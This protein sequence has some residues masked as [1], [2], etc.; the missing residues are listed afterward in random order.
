MT[1]KP[2]IL[3]AW[4]K[5][6]AAR[7]TNPARMIK[8]RCFIPPLRIAPGGG[9][10]QGHGS[11]FRT[12]PGARSLVFLSRWREMFEN[13]EF[14]W[15][16]ARVADVGDLVSCRA[17][18]EGSGGSVQV[19]ADVYLH[20]RAA[21]NGSAPDFRLFAVRRALPQEHRFAIGRPH[22]DTHYERRLGGQ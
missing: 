18:P 9:R 8:R 2:S 7:P 21:I 4:S 11:T 16:L 17:R 12:L 14:R 15:N 20:R 19:D 13:P 3:A 10:S 6:P 22:H 5:N 1:V